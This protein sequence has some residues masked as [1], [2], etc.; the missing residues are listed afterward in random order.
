MVDVDNARTLS[1]GPISVPVPKQ[2]GY[3]SD[4]G[5]E[6][7]ATVSDHAMLTIVIANC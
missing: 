1:S 2:L 5:L 3:A 6:T 4:G 7:Q